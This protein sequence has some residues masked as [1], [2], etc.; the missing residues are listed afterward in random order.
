[1]NSGVQMS[2]ARPA[3]EKTF[4]EKLAFLSRGPVE[5]ECR[6]YAKGVGDSDLSVSGRLEHAAELCKLVR[7]W[8]ATDP[9]ERPAMSVEEF[10]AYLNSYDRLPRERYND[11]RTTHYNPHD[12]DFGNSPNT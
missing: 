3:R 1:M 10:T 11:P 6:R 5:L 4:A 2:P 12:P 8:L 7:E 9:A